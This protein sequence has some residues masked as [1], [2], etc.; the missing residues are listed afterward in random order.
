MTNSPRG[1]EPLQLHLCLKRN[2]E[3]MEGYDRHSESL[4]GP[5][6]NGTGLPH[7]KDLIVIKT[8]TALSAA[9]D[10]QET[11]PVRADEEQ[12]RERV[13]EAQSKNRQNRDSSL[14]HPAH[15]GKL[16]TMPWVFNTCQDFL[17]CFESTVRSPTVRRDHRKWGDRGRE[18]AECFASTAW[19]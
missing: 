1:Q 18:G 4:W 3:E 17:I 9:E 10:K 14:H 8:N 2:M 7:L 16:P 6:E 12:P 5:F 13:Q 11:R 19:A 15:A